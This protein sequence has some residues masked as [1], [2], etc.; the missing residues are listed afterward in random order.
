MG[1]KEKIRSLNKFLLVLGSMICIVWLRI[2][3]TDKSARIPLYFFIV[4]IILDEIIFRFCTMGTRCRIPDDET[5]YN[6]NSEINLEVSVLKKIFY[7]YKYILIIFTEKNQ[8]SGKKIK[9]I[10]K[11]S[12]N[13]YKKEIFTISLN[14]ISYGFTNVNIEKAYVYNVLGLFKKKIK[15]K[16]RNYNIVV[17]PEPI[18][19]KFEA[20]NQK[21]IEVDESDIFSNDRP[22]F[23]PSEIFNLREF[24]DGDG[25]NTVH[26]K[27]SS[28][29]EELIVREFSLPV[30]TNIYVFINLL[31][32]IEIDKQLE[33]IISVVYEL[34]YEDLCFFI[35]WFNNETGR[36][37]RRLIKEIEEIY[38]VFVEMMKY[39]LFENNT[40]Y[41]ESYEKLQTNKNK[42]FITYGNITT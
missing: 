8:Y 2:M 38:D 34:C 35:I 40:I 15:I 12:L 9:H 27:L 11:I 36:F 23:D 7:P 17:V 3:F 33:Y 14:N 10:E 19:I 37:E 6:R 21:Y 4:F 30:E 24:R 25:L 32:N 39:P 18:K 22:G 28:K 26:W 29:S 41:S 13:G 5:I 1:I 31:K 20:P 16:N 42:T